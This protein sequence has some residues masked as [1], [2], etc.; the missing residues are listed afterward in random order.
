MFQP[1]K[2]NLAI[3]FLV[4]FLVRAAAFQFYVGHNERYRQPDS[5]DYNNC[6]SNISMGMCMHKMTTLEPIFWRTPGYP[7]FLAMFQKLVGFT[8]PQ[9]SANHTAHHAAIW[10]QIFLS[11]LVP[12]FIFF[13]IYFLTQIL[14]IA[15]IASWI[16]AL[17]FGPILASTYLLTEA[18]AIFF[19][20]P[21]FLFFYK[22]FT[23]FGEPKRK[24]RWAKN[25]ALAGLFLGIA[26]WIR[27]MGEFVSVVVA[28]LIFCLDQASWKIKFKKVALFFLVFLAITGPWY[29]RNYKITE[30][31]FFC[32]MFGPYLNSF[33]APRILRDVTKIPLEKCHALLGREANER[34][35]ADDIEAYKKGKRSCKHKV[36][37]GVALGVIKRHPFLLVYNWMKEV[38]NTTFDLYAS[39]LVEFAR[40]TFT[41]DLMEEFLLT[42]WKDCIY[43]QAVPIWMRILVFLEI[44]FELLK[45]IGLLCGAWIFLLVPLLKRFRISADRKK[46]GALWLKTAPMIGAFIFMTG[47]FGY[48]RLRLPIEP[49]MIMLSLS[50]WYWILQKKNRR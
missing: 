40:N 15:W 24:V 26:T 42:K 21:F 11:S 4:S 23:T 43:K 27:P 39:Q 9:F 36:A 33:C 28:I 38:F 5:S 3:L 37:L 47:G 22:S 35:Q 17:H 32:P 45:W 12:I 31:I 16:W 18:L 13:L 44:I 46:M 49:L 8:S 20:I 2:K 10:M 50:W 30:K 7:L 41:Y 25:M 14:S 29:L 6:A 34:A 19:L 1:N 48:S